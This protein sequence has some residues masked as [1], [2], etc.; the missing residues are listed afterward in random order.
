MIQTVFMKISIQHN[1]ESDIRIFILFDFY[2]N[3]KSLCN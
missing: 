3:A 1:S 2:V